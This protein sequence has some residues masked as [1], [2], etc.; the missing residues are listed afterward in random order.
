MEYRF[1]DHAV[2][3]FVS[4]SRQMGAAKIKNPEKT[5]QKLLKMAGED[6][7]SRHRLTKRLI[8]NKFTPVRYLAVQGWRFIVSETENIVITVER[9]NP[10]QN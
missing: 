3:Q 10:A 7:L 6:I 8:S 1:T 4:R 2:E 9:I 5:M